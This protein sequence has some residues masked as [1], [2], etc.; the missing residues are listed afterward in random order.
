MDSHQFHPKGWRANNQYHR[1]WYQYENH[2]K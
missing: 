1:H 2:R